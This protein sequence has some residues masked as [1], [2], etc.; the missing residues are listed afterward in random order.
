MVAKLASMLQKFKKKWGTNKV[1]T[2]QKVKNSHAVST[3]DLLVPKKNTMLRLVHFWKI[4]KPIVAV[5]IK[6]YPPTTLRALHVI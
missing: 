5:N 2:R 6:V 1:E 4:L 3:L